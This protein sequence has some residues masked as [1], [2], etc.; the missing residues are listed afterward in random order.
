MVNGVAFSAD[1]RRIASASDDR[2]VKLWDSTTLTPELLLL[3]E[4]RSLVQLRFAQE[5]LREQ[6]ANA[7][8]RDPTIDEPVRRQALA[9]AEVYPENATELNAASWTLVRQ[10]NLAAEKYRQ[11][12]RF[13]EAACRLEP[14]Q[15]QCLNTLG[16]AQYRVADYRE[17]LATLTRSEP[18]NAKSF[19]GPHPSDTAFLAMSHFRLGEKD[20]ARAAFERLRAAMKKVQLAKDP[21]AQAFFREAEELIEGKQGSP[22]R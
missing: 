6:V 5:L 3:R 2:T 13:A 21:E 11:A 18:L 16:V 19:G 17:A 8:Q 4:A 7:I 15:A 14:D 9:L 20:Q 1:G 22:D 12:L 10:R